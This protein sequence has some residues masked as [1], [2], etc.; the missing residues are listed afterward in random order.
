MNKNK[1]IALVPGL[2]LALVS[3]VALA[4]PSPDT[5]LVAGYDSDQMAV[6]YGVSDIDQADGT[7]A[8]LDCTL[9]GTFEYG[10]GT[11][12]DGIAPV[13]TLTAV[14]EDADPGTNDDT[15]FE[16]E[17]VI[18]NPDNDPALSDV[19]YGAVGS[20]QCA[21]TS[22]VIEP[23]GAGEINHGKVVSTFAK[24]L[25]GGNGCLIKLFAQSD[26]GKGE[27]EGA[28]AATFEVELDSYETACAKGKDKVKADPDGGP[29]GKNNAPGQEK[30][31]P[32][33]GNGKDNAPGQLKKADD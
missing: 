31:K 6:V 15:T 21:L 20:E 7:T 10:A 8:T 2:S 4:A 3:S 17:T 24:L 22:V 33:R 30:D 14:D 9:V 5:L 23:N 16:P 29:N 28:D 11:A 19:E 1:L 25:Q 12:V 26:F 13:D 32:H 18:E 27:Y